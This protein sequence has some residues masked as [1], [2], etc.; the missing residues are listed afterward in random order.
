MLGKIIHRGL[1]TLKRRCRCLQMRTHKCANHWRCKWMPD[2][3][4]G[5]PSHSLIGLKWINTVVRPCFH[6]ELFCNCFPNI[7]CDS[8]TLQPTS[9]RPL[10]GI[11]LREI[12]ATKVGPLFFFF[13]IGIKLRE[14]LACKRWVQCFCAL[15]VLRRRTRGGGVLAGGGHA[16]FIFPSQVCPALSNSGQL[17]KS[18]KETG[19]TL[20]R[21]SQWHSRS[22]HRRLPSLSVAGS[23]QAKTNQ[24]Y[25]LQ[26]T[27]FYIGLGWHSSS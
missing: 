25:C 23:Q 4:S 10:I 24:L 8:L 21:S 3:F 6:W 2:S 14:I 27:V 17:S 15:L 5:H 12:P 20:V 18:L 1:Q 16:V 19:S 7:V 9:Q 11:M 26:W 13:S 22:R